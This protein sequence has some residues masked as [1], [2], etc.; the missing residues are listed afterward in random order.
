MP[1]H[2][3]TKVG[4][5][6]SLTLVAAVG[7]GPKADQAA[8]PGGGGEKTIHVGY[9]QLGEDSDF[10]RAETASIK[11]E[12]KIR[13]IDLKYADAQGKQENQISAIR[14]FIQQK[15]DAILISPVVET[16]WEP[17][18]KE[19]KAANIPV[20]LVDHKA[21]LEDESLYAC[22]VGADLV[23]EGRRAGKKLAELLGGKGQ[24][25]VIAGL[26]GSTP[27]IDRE[28]GFEDALKGF[29]D[30]K[31]AFN[32]NAEW[33]RAKGKEAMEACL[34]AN[35]NING[36]F[37]H[38]DD[39]GMGAAG[40][41]SEAGL[42]PGQDVKLVSVDGIKDC[43]TAIAD[44]KY[45]ASIECNPLLGPI[46]FDTVKKVVAKQTVDK[47]I[48]LPDQMFDASNAAKLLPQRQY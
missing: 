8:N 23:E 38:N 42:K 14:N 10:R 17:V 37:S 27:A 6:L 22:F 32:Q 13:G 2:R 4:L 46:L 43:L 33:N 44:G 20:I 25:A 45:S 29:P 11:N 5:A 31:V 36:V 24:V 15:V 16:G 28:K 34:K 9:A 12:A 7:C 48:I 41:I 26:P 18:L 30:I 40:A 3:P 21:K 35:R 39:M 19:A 47:T 1:T